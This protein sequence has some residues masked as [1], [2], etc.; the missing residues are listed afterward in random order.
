M[1]WIYTWIKVSGQGSL[2]ELALENG[3]EEWKNA[4][5]YDFKTASSGIPDRFNGCVGA[6]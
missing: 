1:E 6:W 3:K 4:L 5:F 2:D